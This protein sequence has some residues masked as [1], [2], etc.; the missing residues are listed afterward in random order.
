M[1][2]NNTFETTDAGTAEAVWRIN[3]YRIAE[4]EIKKV[5]AAIILMAIIELVS[6]PSIDF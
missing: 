6:N 1:N 3:V 2:Y 5:V 4:G